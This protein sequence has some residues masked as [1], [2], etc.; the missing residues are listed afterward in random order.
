MTPQVSLDLSVDVVTLT[1]AVC[2]IA[3][4]SGTEGVLA[5]RIEEALRAWPHLRVQRDGDAVVARTELG[6]AERVIIA[7]H[8]DTV[9]IAGNL[10][11]RREGDLLWGRG[12]VDMKSG[13]AVALR[14]AAHVTSPNRDVTYVFYDNEEVEAVK[15]GLG[16]LLRN[17][18]DWL[19]G[20]FAILMEPTA[21]Q[22]E[23]GCNG[24]MRV[25]VTTRGRAAHS[26]RWW[27]GSNAIHAAGEVLTRLRSYRPEEIEVDGLTYREGLNAVGIR[28]GI[29]GNVIPDECVVSVNYRFAP[30]RTPADA[31]A[32]VRDI[33]SGFD[34]TVTDMSPGARPGLT[35]PAVKAFVAAVGGEPLP[36]YGWTDVARFSELGVP[37]INYGP[38]D[39]GLAHAD[40]E[41]VEASEIRRCEERMRAWLTE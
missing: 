10:P 17:H 11:I 8:I 25:D 24:S 13:V 12:T 6:R 20:D 39:P 29:A 14:L 23:G 31:E 9:P 40:D 32:H 22:V 30:S 35:H 27:Q 3:S 21:A 4:V 26:A 5:D 36:K 37:A 7:G 19:V 18:P 34:V 1:A 15:S 38:G 41:R 2:D 16:R 28:G 33:F